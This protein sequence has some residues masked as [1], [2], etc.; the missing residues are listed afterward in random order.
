[1]KANSKKGLARKGSIKKTVI[2]NI[3]NGIAKDANQKV[4]TYKIFSKNVA[5]NINRF[6]TALN[7]YFPD[8]TRE[9]QLKAYKEQRFVFKNPVIIQ[10]FKSI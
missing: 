3:N 7:K 8:M 10:A 4:T 5:K 2:F 9:E 1:M 6:N